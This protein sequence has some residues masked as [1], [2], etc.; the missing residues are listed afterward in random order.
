VQRIINAAIKTPTGVA[1]TQLLFGDAVHLERGILLPHKEIEEG[2]EIPVYLKKLL[3][4]QSDLIKIAQE[5]EMHKK[6][7]N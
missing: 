6:H 4:T 5:K 1:P 7:L 3:A 2:V